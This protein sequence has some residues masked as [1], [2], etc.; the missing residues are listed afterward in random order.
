LPLAALDDAMNDAPLRIDLVVTEMFVGGAERCL[1]ELAIGLRS[2][3]DT[4]RVASIGR[5][6]TG[7]KA[8][9]VERL[10]DH[11]IT[12]QSAGCDSPWQAWNA[13]RWLRSWFRQGRPEVVQ[14]MLFHANVLGTFAARAAG[15]PVCVGG[16]RVAEKRGTRLLI[17]KQ[18]IKRM[19]AV[20]CVSRSVQRFA[21]EVFG[22]TAVPKHVIGNAIDIDAVDQV[23][24]VDWTTLG[25]PSDAQVVLF[26]GRLHHQKGID[27]LVEAIRPLLAQTNS[28]GGQQDD[29]PMR[30]LLVGDGP[31]RQ[32][33]QQEAERLGPD[34]FQL[35]GWRADCMALIK[36]CRLLVLPSRYEGMPNV[37]MEAMAAGKP[38]AATTVHGVEELLGASAGGQTCPPED[39]AALRQLIEQLWQDRSAAEEL[40]RINR[41]R[42]VSSHRIDAMIDRYRS[43][44]ASITASLGDR[45]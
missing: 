22:Q 7:R 13:Y 36:G 45:K 16:L 24:P 40:G 19:N 28:R 11:Q 6:P 30:C 4:V 35:A 18:A 14:T 32:S 34:R 5:L 41:Q 3:G 12:V 25:W 8:A 15:V 17:E 10:A 26:V 20:I 29:R 2:R 31:L 27:L 33:L 23:P 43:V 42:V 1:T 39:P 37:V 38:V 9:L 21:D 44:Y